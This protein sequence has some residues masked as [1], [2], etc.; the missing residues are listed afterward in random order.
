MKKFR[1]KY[2]LFLLLLLLLI[3]GG[4]L[5]FC[6]NKPDLPFL[7]TDEN[8]DTWDG[9]QDLNHRKQ[10]IDTIAIPGIESLVFVANQQEQKVNFYNPAENE[11]TLFQL[12]LYVNDK[13]YWKSGNI[14]P[15]KGYYN[16]TLEEPL[17]EGEYQAYLEYKCCTLQG[18]PL[19]GA[20]VDFKL[21]VE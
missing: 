7:P 8:A 15:G 12:T 13:E 14:E 11:D 9:E 20:K 21:Y 2:L 10:D 3:A 18:V 6:G 17:K 16:I 5:Y 19:N 1:K 4:I